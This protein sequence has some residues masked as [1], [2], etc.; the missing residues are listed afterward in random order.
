MSWCFHDRMREYKFS[1]GS[2]IKMCPDCTEFDNK[3]EA[4]LRTGS[5]VIPQ[6]KEKIHWNMLLVKEDITLD[7][8][9]D[10]WL[11]YA[12][13]T[14][15][16]QKAGEQSGYVYV[17]DLHGAFMGVM[18]KRLQQAKKK[19]TPIDDHE[20]V[21][22]QKPFPHTLSMPRKLTAYCPNCTEIVLSVKKPWVIRMTKGVY[23]PIEHECNSV[24]VYDL[25]NNL[26][27]VKAQ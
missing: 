26:L 27:E 19:P 23:L 8:G 10:Y 3:R 20:W 5:V 25:N 16:A 14:A 21:E 1:D 6:S 11:T 17:A 12:G 24:R 15:G 7:D 2:I 18:V 22:R 9:L 4:V 13:D